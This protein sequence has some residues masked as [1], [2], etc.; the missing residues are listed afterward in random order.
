MS[1]ANYADFFQ[2]IEQSWYIS[3]KFQ[4]HSCLQAS[5]LVSAFDRFSLVLLA[6][7]ALNAANKGNRQALLQWRGLPFIFFTDAFSFIKSV[8]SPK[9]WDWG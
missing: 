7:L 8:Q 2:E 9:R 3:K 5:S 6:S 1:S 4:G